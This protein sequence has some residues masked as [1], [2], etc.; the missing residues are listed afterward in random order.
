MVDTF[1]R[2]TESMMLLAALSAPQPQGFSGV[3]AGPSSPRTHCRPWHLLQQGN[4]RLKTNIS[5]RNTRNMSIYQLIGQPAQKF[6]CFQ[7][8]D[9]N[10]MSSILPD[11]KCPR[12]WAKWG[13]EGELRG[14]SHWVQLFI[15]AQI[16]FWDPTPYLAYV[17]KYEKKFDQFSGPIFMGLKWCRKSCKMLW[18]NNKIIFLWTVKQVWFF[19][20]R[21]HF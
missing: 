14:L 20:H 4:N 16:N 15:I 6:L 3:Q 8:G 13:K 2:C 1:R 5:A 12:I 7:A 21:K 17:C 10:E 19:C 9:Y 11:Q 18:N